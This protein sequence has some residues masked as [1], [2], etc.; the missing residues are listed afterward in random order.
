MMPVVG[1]AGMTHLGLVSAS[2][3]A[4]RGFRTVGFD[5][6][7]AVIRRLQDGDLPVNEPGLPELIDDHRNNLTFCDDVAALRDCDVIYVAVDVPTDDRGLSDLTP[8][9]S[10]VERVRPH[11]GAT[12]LLV[13]LSQVPPGFTRA[14][15][16]LSG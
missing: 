2:A 16:V 3:A 12:R 10:M 13:V 4:A 15:P 9:A 6:D 8:I 5:P 7:A 11:L 14:L 1:F